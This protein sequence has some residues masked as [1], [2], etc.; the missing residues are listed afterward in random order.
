[1]SSYT[2]ATRGHDAEWL[3]QQER[4]FNDAL[5]QAARRR[6]RKTRDRGNQAGMTVLPL[7]AAEE[8]AAAGRIREV[9]HRRGVDN[10][11]LADLLNMLGVA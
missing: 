9:A 2:T 1:M 8:L 3:L 6:P 7:T 11:E 4:R 5:L 10:T